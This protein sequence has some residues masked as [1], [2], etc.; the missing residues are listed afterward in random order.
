[1]LHPADDE[2]QK[3][4]TVVQG[5]HLLSFGTAHSML[6]GP[7]KSMGL[8]LLSFG[9]AHSKLISVDLLNLFLETFSS[10]LWFFVLIHIHIDGCC[11]WVCCSCL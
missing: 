9:T 3:P 1:M 5:L 2:G 4:E 6:H 8:H 10:D 7:I 11:G